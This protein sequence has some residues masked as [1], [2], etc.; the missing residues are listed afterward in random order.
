VG[1]HESQPIRVLIIDDSAFMRRALTR[2]INEGQG[3]TVVGVAA[4]G[5]EGLELLA[6]LRPDVVT[7]DVEMPDMDGVA[8]LERIM[9]RQPLPVVM[10]SS[11]TQRGAEVTLK[12]LELGAVDCIGKPSGSVSE[13]LSTIRYIIWATL[14]NAAGAQVS[15]RTRSLTPPPPPRTTA[16]RP[17]G[18]A[19][20][21]VVIG[22]STG[23]PRALMDVLELLPDN[24][25]AALIVVQHLPAHFT[26]TLAQ[27]LDD[28]CALA[29]REA[30]EGDRLTAGTAFL[31]PGGQHL[32]VTEARTLT[33]SQEPPR[34]GVRPAVDVPMEDAATLYRM[35]CLG[36]VLT[37]MGHDGTAGLTA[38]KQYR[39][40]TL[41]QDA[42]SCVV[43]GMPRSAME[44]GVAD[45]LLPLT[46]IADAITQWSQSGQLPPA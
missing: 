36:V 5:R 21:L 10:C 11:L 9:A 17:Q 27:R 32:H 20:R 46:E 16:P 18:L 24:L 19:R 35:G 13:D 2:V 33:L 6:T 7:L 23:G 8:V 4:S 38:I 15:R 41:A 25:P 28:R 43:F 40:S 30:Q 1:A 12:C 3:F 29:V 22:A 34:W 39:G 37:G 31:A 14:R 26:A 44:A 45:R 42:E